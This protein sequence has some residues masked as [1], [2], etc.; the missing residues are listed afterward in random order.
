VGSVRVDA[1]G[2]SALAAHCEQQAAVV[3]SIAS[4]ELSGSGFQPSSAAV[5]AAHGDVVAAGARLVGRIKSTAV[6]AAT[7][8]EGY[9]TTDSSSANNLATVLQPGTT[10]V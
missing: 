1:V 7:T 5:Q 8:A 6:A 10:A 3:G 9:V 2:L 4:P